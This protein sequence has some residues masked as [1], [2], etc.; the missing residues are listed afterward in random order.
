MKITH[1]PIY[2]RTDG[3]AK[4]IDFEGSIH[5]QV[6][7]LVAFKLLSTELHVWKYRTACM[8]ILKEDQFKKE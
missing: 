5:C 1:F 4:P 3:D 8:K 7:L 6:I 2:E